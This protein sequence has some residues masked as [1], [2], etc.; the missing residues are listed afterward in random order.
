MIRNVLESPLICTIGINQFDFEDYFN[1]LNNLLIPNK[2]YILIDMSKHQPDYIAKNTNGEMNESKNKM[3]IF[4]ELL[5][6]MQKSKI[7]I[8]LA[9]DISPVSMKK[10]IKKLTN[11]NVPVV[12]VDMQNNVEI[13]KKEQ[14]YSLFNKDGKE[15]HVKIRK[16]LSEMMNWIDFEI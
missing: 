15:Y 6:V 12:G 2:D 1:N 13:N 5:P 9:D 8:I 11:F 16:S 4:N 7:R 3:T 14:V 10:F